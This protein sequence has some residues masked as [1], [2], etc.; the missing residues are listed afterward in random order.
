MPNRGASL[1]RQNCPLFRF[2][3]AFSFVNNSSGVRLWLF[4]AVIDVANHQ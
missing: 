1:F 4:E 3:P 2:D